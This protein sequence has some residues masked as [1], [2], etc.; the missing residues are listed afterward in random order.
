MIAN[1]LGQDVPDFRFDALHHFAGALD[2][3]DIATIFQF[4]NDERLEK[5]QRHFFWQ[6]ALVHFELR[7]HH[8]D[9]TARIID[10][11]SQKVLAET[12]L[13]ALEHVGKRFQG[14]VPGSTDSVAPATVIQK[15]VYRF[16]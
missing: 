8:D 11:F 3:V 12:A 4:F 16:L 6:S 1:N 7:T 14:A 10:A 9:G 15:R 2:G 5:F 13:F